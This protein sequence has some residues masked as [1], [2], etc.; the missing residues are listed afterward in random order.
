MSAFLLVE[1]KD[2]HGK[3]IDR[4]VVRFI[5]DIRFVHDPMK[6]KRKGTSQNKTNHI[7]VVLDHRLLAAIRDHG[8]FF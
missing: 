3:C 2:E 7:F 5:Q 4:K 8:Y 1:E 6:N